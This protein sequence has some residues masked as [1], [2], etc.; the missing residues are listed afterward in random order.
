[1]KVIVVGH[2]PG[3]SKI[4]YRSKSATIKRLD[5]W[6]GACDVYSYSFV[7]LFAPSSH[8]PQKNEVNEILLH[9]CLNG[10]NKIITLGNE[11]SQ[12]FSKRNI[13]HF[14]ASHPSPRN[15]KFND[16][17]FEPQLI[18]NLKNYLFSKK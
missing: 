9:E 7:N 6:L 17:S 16:K 18:E 15:R 8:S 13:P 1:M 14:A 4:K 3:S 5:M 2:S 11:V 12:Y 10:Y